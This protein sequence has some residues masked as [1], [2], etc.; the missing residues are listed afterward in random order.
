M[1]T[2]EENLVR[3]LHIGAIEWLITLENGCRWLREIVRDMSL[4]LQMEP[5]VEGG[6]ISL[7][8]WMKD[9]SEDMLAIIWELEEGPDPWLDVSI[10]WRRADGIMSICKT[11]FNW[12]RDLYALLEHR[13]EGVIDREDTH[14]A[15]EVTALNNNSGENIINNNNNNNNNNINSNDDDGGI[16]GYGCRGDDSGAWADVIIIDIM[17]EMLHVDEGEIGVGTE[18]GLVISPHPLND[19]DDDDNNNNNINDDDDDGGHHQGSSGVGSGIRL[20]VIVISVKGLMPQVDG[21]GQGLDIKKRFTA[22]SPSNLDTVFL[23]V[24][25]QRVGIGVG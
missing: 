20:S 12:G 25:W 3:E 4:R 21:V 18:K 8:G 1:T 13:L 7:A 6:A 11:L 19:E 15:T 22:F 16:D 24:V 9:K 23:L 14:V 17:G 5:E 10:D 2:T